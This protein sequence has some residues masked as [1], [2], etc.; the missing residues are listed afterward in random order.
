MKLDKTTLLILI[1][2]IAI[3]ALLVIINY[4]SSNIKYNAPQ[5]PVLEQ[6]P[7]SE[8]KLDSDL[9]VYVSND[10]C[11]GCHMSG[12]PFIPQA[13]TVKAHA[14]GGAYC[15]S[16]HK[17][18]HETHPINDKITCEK[19]HGAVAS[20]PKFVDGNISC[21]NCHAYPDPLLPSGGNLI[22]VHRER[23]VAC[24]DCHTDECRKCHGEIGEDQQWKKRFTH[25]RTIMQTKYK[26]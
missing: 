26:N 3:P 18:S 23:G 13:T 15:L 2:T 24:N 10:I 6:Q 7:I 11:E 21:N 1:V 22:S 20:M 8:N 4:E 17:I 14:Y 25:F 16:C 5:I 19:C 12:K 9:T